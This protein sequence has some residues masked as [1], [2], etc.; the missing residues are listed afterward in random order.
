MVKN[1]SVCKVNMTRLTKTA[2]EQYLDEE[3]IT[4]NNK[5]IHTSRSVVYMIVEYLAFALSFSLKMIWL[6][7]MAH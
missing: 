3:F 6:H 7:L 5:D 2:C 1:E 4:Q